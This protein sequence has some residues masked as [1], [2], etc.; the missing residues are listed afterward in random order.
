MPGKVALYRPGH[1]GDDFGLAY[2]Q[3][4]E[5]NLGIEVE[6][7]SVHFAVA[8]PAH[9]E[10]RLAQSLGR[11]ARAAYGNAARCRRLLD[12]SDRLVVIS[13]LCRSFLPGWAR[14][15]HDEI[16]GIAHH[17]LPEPQRTH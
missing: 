14:T 7:Q 8:K 17:F 15:N 11:D 12:K 1:H 3:T 2:H 5:G 9:I 6:T 13:C 16:K 10:G 4:F